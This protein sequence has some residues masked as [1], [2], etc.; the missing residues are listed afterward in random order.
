LHEATIDLLDG[1]FYASGPYEAY[2]WLRENAPLYWDSTNELWGI[3]RYD[4]VVHIEKRK[5]VFISSDKVKGGFRPNLPADTSLIGLDDPLHQSRRNLVSRQFTPKGVSR[6]VTAIRGEVTT[7]LNDVADKGGSAEIVSELAAP[8]PAAVIGRLL[9]FTDDM[10]M[11]LQQWSER[12]IVLGGGPRYQDDA[13]ILAAYEF[14]QAA[15]DL[16]EH[17]KRC[18]RD[19]IMTVW[20]K[21][22]TV[23][24]LDRDD[25]ISDSLLLLDG[26]AE[27]SRTVIARTLVNFTAHAEQWAALQRGANLTV[28]VEEFIR[29]VTPV[30]NMCRVANQDYQ[31]AGGMVPQGHQVLLMYGSANRDPAHFAQPECFDVT[32][33]PNSHLSF[34]FGT[35]FCLGAA[36]ARL[37]IRIFFE[38]LLNRVRAFRMTP[39]TEPVEMPNAFIY[40]LRSAHLDF[41]F[42]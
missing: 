9:G 14:A 28:A 13:G 16:Y 22:E 29:Y 37:E 6:W 25:I 27:T 38:E 18:P 21:A 32:R 39:G 33:H 35:H 31:I 10:R 23:G 3:S 20:T 7:L 40:G 19:D 1:D 17:K 12:T 26:G 30:H 4:D 36:L 11:D 34:G 8:L 5:D 2:A 41:D 15:A 42:K 24:A